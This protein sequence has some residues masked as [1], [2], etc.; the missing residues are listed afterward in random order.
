MREVQTSGPQPCGVIWEH[1]LQ[2][3]CY[4][5]AL[6]QL[7][8]QMQDGKCLGRNWPLDR[9][10]TDFLKRPRNKTQENRSVRKLSGLMLQAVSACHASHHWCSTTGT[11]QGLC[12]R[13][14]C[15]HRSPRALSRHCGTAGLHIELTVVQREE[16]LTFRRL[17]KC[18]G[19]DVQI[20]AGEL[21]E[22]LSRKLWPESHREAAIE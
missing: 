11:Y 1:F 4:H 2:Y 16:G 13:G 6:C 22:S 10:C 20:P 18:P 7:V 19:E 15:S 3:G 9:L 14:R 5:V 17:S 8:K 21:W 12:G